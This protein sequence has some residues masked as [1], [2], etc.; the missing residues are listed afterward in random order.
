VHAQE[1][2]TGINPPILLIEAESPAKIE[3]PITLENQSDTNTTYGIYLR[4]FKANFDM[5]GIPNYDPELMSKYE[6]FFKK[7]QVQAGDEDVTEISLAPK[8]SK[9]LVLKI[10]V[11]ASEP[12]ADK[13]FTIIFLANPEEKESETNLSGARGGIGTNILLSVG[14]KDKPEGR[15]A[16]FKAPFFVSHGPVPFELELA[17][18]NDYYVV[19]EGNVVIKNMFN[20]I[21]GNLEFGPINILANSNRLIGDTNEANAKLWWNEKYPIG[22]YQAQVKVALSERGPLLMQNISFIAFPVELVIAI[23]IIII[24]LIWIIRRVRKKASESN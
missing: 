20:Q 21:V 15:I 13:Y 6:S 18:H 4:P 1:F 22:I 16:S 3:A 2:S 11:E 5:S 10:E 12:P 7:V 19:S 24:A 23:F 9:D 17:N 8:E 14:P